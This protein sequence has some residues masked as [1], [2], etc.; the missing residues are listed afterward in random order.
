MKEK[1]KSLLSCLNQIKG[2]GTFATS[3]VQKKML[4]GLVVKGFGE[5]GFPLNEI[6]IKALKKLSRQAPYGKGRQTIT[7]TTVRK[8]WEI[9]ANQIIFS[10]K[11]KDKH[12]SK[13]VKVVKKGLGLV[14]QEIE[15]VLY[16]LLIYETGGFF[17]PHKDSEKADGMFGTL[18]ICLP[19]KHTGGSLLVRFAG[20]E[21]VIDF[22]DDASNYK[23]PFAAF[24]ADCEHEIKPVTSGYRICLVFNLLSNGNK[25]TISPPDI[26]DTTNQLAKQLALLAP[27]FNDKPKAILL[28]HQYTPANFSIDELKG[29][30]RPRTQALLLAAEK[31]SYFATLGLLT[32]YQEGELEGDFYSEYTSYRKHDYENFA[33]NGTMGEVYE[34]GLW[35]RHWGDGKTPGLGKCYLKLEDVITDLEIGSG[36]PIEQEEEGYTGNAG[37]TIEYWYHYG[38]VILWPR[39][40]HEKIINEAS[41]SVILNWMRFYLSHWNDKSIDARNVSKRIFQKLNVKK[42]NKDSYDYDYDYEE[43]N[44]NV[45]AEILIKYDDV[46]LIKQN[47]AVISAAISFIE[48]PVFIK[49]IKHYDPQLFAPVFQQASKT[50][51]LQV[52][53]HL[54]GILL[55]LKNETKNHLRTF[56]KKQCKQIPAY[57]GKIKLTR[58]KNTGTYHSLNEKNRKTTIANILNKLLLISSSFAPTKGWIEN[59]FL[60]CTTKMSREYIHEVLSPELLKVENKEAELFIKLHGICTKNLEQR[61]Q[62][63]PSPPKTWK[64]SIPRSKSDEDVWD[65]L[66]DFMK[67]PTQKVFNYTK[68]ESYRSRVEWAIKNATVDLKTETIRKGRP[69]TL[70]ITKTQ[71]AYRLAL[72]HWKEDIKLLSQ[73]KSLT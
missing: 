29:S 20:E 68:N 24:Y 69:Y 58:T 45:L 38:A 55:G 1:I 15:A 61:T 37:M 50:Y 14:D 9:D 60:Q 56:F 48:E 64:R 63:K 27:S 40:M 7:D 72:R 54:L 21:K 51:D 39:T 22:S 28:G 4:L 42:L 5:L 10:K 47:N 13:I 33:G 73:L 26:S 31:S 43:W 25:K 41:V 19:S 59:I 3:G 12:L 52:I 8:A 57:I 49:L 30:D 18:V 67:S 36:K 35:I 70:K 66:A 11:V 6:Q 16:K 53:D 65:L 46:K 44:C 2:S 23:V 17:L 32:Y 71:T 62:L 34:E